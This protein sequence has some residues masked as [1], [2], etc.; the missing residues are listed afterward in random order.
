MVS[1]SINICWMWGILTIHSPF[2]LSLAWW[3]I[4]GISINLSSRNKASFRSKAPLMMAERE[5]KL[6]AT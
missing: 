2:S 5:C 3:P 1:I 6:L 4:P